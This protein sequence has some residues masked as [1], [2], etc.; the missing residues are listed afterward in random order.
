MS[1]KIALIACSKRKL[2]KN[3]PNQSF[4]AQDIYQGNI[5]KTAKEKGLKKFACDDWF[6]LSGK[7]D[8]NLLDKNSKIKYYD[9]YLGKQKIAY[10]KSWAEKVLT[11]LKQKGFNLQNDIF[12]IF[13]GKA[14][15]EYLLPKLNHCVVFKFKSSSVIDLDKSIHYENGVKQND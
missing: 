15:Y 10:K 6:I 1:Q 8:Y 13:G 3:T 11:K 4:L 7:E 5:F 2:G 14:Y 9:C 12:Y